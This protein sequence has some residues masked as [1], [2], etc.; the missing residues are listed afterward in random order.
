MIRLDNKNDVQ[1]QFGKSADSNNIKDKFRVFIEEDQVIS[2]Q[3]EAI[4]L[5]AIKR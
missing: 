3:G 1:Q 4:V 5:K 2:F